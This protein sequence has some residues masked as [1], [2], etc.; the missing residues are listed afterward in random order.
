M[1]RALNLNQ[2]FGHLT[3]QSR[4]LHYDG[5]FN[6]REKNEYRKDLYSKIEHFFA[7]DEPLEFDFYFDRIMFV[8]NG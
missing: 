7:G 2:F 6:D 5:R 3:S 4:Y 1:K 8:K